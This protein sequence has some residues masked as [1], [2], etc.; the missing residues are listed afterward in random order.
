[1]PRHA[2]RES[3]PPWPPFPPQ[4]VRED[5]HPLQP[6]PPVLPPPTPPLPVTPPASESFG[7]V[8]LVVGMLCVTAIVTAMVLTGHTATA[9]GLIAMFVFLWAFCKI[10]NGFRLVAIELIRRLR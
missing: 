8:L 4:P 9:G 1:M 7:P 6:L 10:V 2:A 5:P 3:T